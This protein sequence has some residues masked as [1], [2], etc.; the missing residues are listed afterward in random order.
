[1]KILQTNN[2]TRKANRLT[3]KD[4]SLRNKLR[5]VIFK[6]G[7]NPFD[8]SLFTHKLK[9]ELEGKYSSRLTFD[10]R[11]IFKY[12]KENNED[13]ILLLTIGSHDEVY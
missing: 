1:M 4:E 11:I 6:L 12:V 9:G 3:R 13:R 5:E 8:H 2:F 10:L 7:R